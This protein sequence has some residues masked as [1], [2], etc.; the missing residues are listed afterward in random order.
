M[1]D[2]TAINYRTVFYIFIL[3]T[4]ASVVTAICMLGNNDLVSYVLFG[5]TGA[6][7]LVQLLVATLAT[8]L[9]RKSK[10]NGFEQWLVSLE[11]IV[12]SML[13]IVFSPILFVLWIVDTVQQRN[14]ARH[15][16]L[17]VQLASNGLN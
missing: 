14:L 11:V 6:A 1:N 5:A 17:D 16:E 13:L 15:L 2:K 3:L 9:K 10:V 7:L 4:V 12:V 8:A